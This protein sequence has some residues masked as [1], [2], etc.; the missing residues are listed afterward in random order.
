[1]VLDRAVDVGLAGEQDRH[2]H[3]VAGRGVT[4]APS[5]FASAPSVSRA[6]PATA[7][8]FSAIREPIVVVARSAEPE[9]EA[10]PLVA[11][12]ADDRDVHRGQTIA[13][14]RGAATVEPGRA[15]CSYLIP[16]SRSTTA[17]AK[18]AVGL[19]QAYTWYA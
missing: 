12:P 15:P 2:D 13:E 3:D 11:G 10:E 17:N 4:L 6:V 7:D 8:P 18:P 19:P 9:R 5:T 1:M 16:T 14:G